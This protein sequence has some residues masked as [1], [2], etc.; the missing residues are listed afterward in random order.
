MPAS[1]IGVIFG[2]RS[3]EHEVS[4][5]TAHQTMAI[6][7]QSRY[8]VVPIYIAKSGRWYTGE[9]LRDLKQFQDLG[10][11][12]SAA[13]P[14]IF[15]TDAT[16]P[17]L[18]SQRAGNRQGLFAPRAKS[19]PFIPLDIAFPILHGSH[20]E[21]GT[22]QGLL[23]LADLPYVGSNVPASA[24][25]M[26]KLLT[27]IVLR[28]AGL[29]VLDDLA[30]PRAEWE[31]APDRI[32]A[33][34]EAR[35]GYPVFVKPVTLGSSIAVTRANDVLALRQALDVAAVY[36][37]RLMIEPA[38]VDVTEINCAVLGDD[39]SVRASVCEQPVTGEMLSY[40]DKY[41]RGSKG[42][43]QSQGMKSAQRI[44]P[45]PISDDLTERIQDAA[46]RTFSA[47]G[48]AGVARIDF[49]VYPDRDVFFVNEINPIPGSLS[50]YLWEP[51]GLSFADL[52][53]TLIDI[54]LVR[55]R[56]K[57][58]NTYSFASSLLANNPLAGSKATGT[59]AA[60]R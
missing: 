29:P 43:G 27:K 15:S 26:D 18:V 21:D 53:N 16:Q 23:E 52:V 17:G 31:R 30:V 51:A 38:Q 35:F 42:G 58:R 59:R 11:L 56:D 2:G 40:A 32:I 12:E 6:L 55:H 14:V 4:V 36:D 19:D 50:F 57:H 60:T 13:E 8:D 7:A 9:V 20:G 54:A 48:A 25:A 39:R 45:A 47:I 24:L 34:S 10:R 5:I 46:Q 3:V 28:A 33:E 1:R 37:S 41:L 44:I 22:L 49:L